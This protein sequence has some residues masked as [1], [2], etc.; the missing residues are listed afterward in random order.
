MR[1]CRFKVKLHIPNFLK[2]LNINE[3]DKQKMDDVIKKYEQLVYDA[4]EINKTQSK[5]AKARMLEICDSGDG[6]NLSTTEEFLEKYP[7]Q[8]YGLMAGDEGWRFVP[9]GLCRSRIENRWGSRDF[10]SIMTSSNGVVLLN[11][12]V[13]RINFYNFYYS[14]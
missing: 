7:G 4:F 9:R 1:L 6:L 5:S 14:I 11:F 12:I 8:A 13:I 3:D 2:A 10:I